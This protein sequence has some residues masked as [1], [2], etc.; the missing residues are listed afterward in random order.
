MGISSDGELMGMGRRV[1]PQKRSMVTQSD[2]L[3]RDVSEQWP[4]PKMGILAVVKQSITL[5]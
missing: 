5:K 1:R 4:F 2:L 3:T